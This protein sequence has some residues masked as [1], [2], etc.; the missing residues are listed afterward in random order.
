MWWL[1]PKRKGFVK[2]VDCNINL[3]YYPTPVSF[4]KSRYHFSFCIHLF[5]LTEY[6]C[7]YSSISCFKMYSHI[8]FHMVSVNFSSSLPLQ[9]ETS[10]LHYAN[11]YANSLH[12]MNSQDKNSTFIVNVNQHLINSTPAV[13]YTHLDVYKRQTPQHTV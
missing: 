3:E 6:R 12:V 8:I 11:G 1:F 9:R 7:I 2:T 13:S 4:S 10:F 5:K